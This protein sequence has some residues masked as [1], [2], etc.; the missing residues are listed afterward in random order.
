M[1]AIQIL[2]VFSVYLVSKEELNV[3]L[4]VLSG[5]S[6]EA[7]IPFPKYLDFQNFMELTKTQTT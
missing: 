6:N 5:L 2:T 4:K 7:L 1:F 3:M